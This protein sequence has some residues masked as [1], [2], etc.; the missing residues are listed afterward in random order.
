MIPH[1]H[2]VGIADFCHLIL[3]SIQAMIWNGNLYLQH[4]HGRHRS[5]NF[6]SGVAMPQV[7]PSASRD[8]KK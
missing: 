2:I 5:A 3:G 4:L 7:S 1:I 6:V 8:K